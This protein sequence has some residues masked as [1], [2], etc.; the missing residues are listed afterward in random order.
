MNIE[1]FPLEK[2]VIEGADMCLGTDRSS[3]E[4]A[5]GEG[6]R[7]RNRY[8]YYG[9]EMAIDYDKDQRVEFIEF[10]GGIE[11]VL[12]PVIYGVSAFELF[13][14][15]LFE[16]LRQKNGG[17]II[18]NERGYCYCFPNISVG[19]YRERIPDDVEEMIEGAKADGEPFDENEIA[20]E[21][22]RAEHWATIGIGVKGYYRK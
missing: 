12:Q 15:E 5:I 2:V 11:G 4:T 1:L 19:V 22:R 3:V 16:L 7:I 20:E 13:A 18:D 14:D 8:Y 21:R 6:E 10:L 17:E 9:S